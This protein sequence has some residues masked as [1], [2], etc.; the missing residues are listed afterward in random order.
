MPSLGDNFLKVAAAGSE[1]TMAS[2]GKPLSATSFNIVDATGWPTDTAFVVAIRVVDQ[3]GNEV[4]NTYTEWLGTLSGTTISL[5]SSPSPVLG[6]DYNYPAG[7]TTEV[8]IPLSSFRDNRLIAAVLQQH[9]QSGTHTGLTTDTL[10]ASGNASVGGTLGVTGAS[11]FTGAM[12][13]AGYSNA[14]IGTPS[15]FSAYKSA[16]TQSW[17]STPALCVFDVKEYDTGS[18]YSTSTNLFT[19]PVTG[20]YDFWSTIQINAFTGSI[21]MQLRVNGSAVKEFPQPQSGSNGGGSLAFPLSLSANDTVGIYVYTNGGT[22][23]TQPGETL[24]YF[25]GRIRSKT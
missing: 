8:Y 9:T 22:I 24:T 7:S 19:A 15:A 14:T 4:A 17:N 2:P 25:A 18:N 12:G 1:T 3:N 5:G 16:T 6:S 10:L 20:I 23:T 21:Y 13:G 11:T